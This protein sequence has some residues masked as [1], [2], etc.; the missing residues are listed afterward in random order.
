MIKNAYTGKERMEAAFTG[1]KLDRAP[2]FLLLG[3]HLAEEAG[4][5]LTQVMTE[6][7]AALKATKFLCDRI[8]TDILFV[9]FNPWLPSTQEAIRKLMGEPISSR[10]RRDLR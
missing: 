1:E 5:T 4:F 6:P 7:E 3:G 2:V 8:D 10:S 9:P